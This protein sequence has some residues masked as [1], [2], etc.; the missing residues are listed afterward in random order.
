MAA[1][2][3]IHLLP[4]PLTID[5]VI[6][7]CP[8]QRHVEPKGFGISIK[9]LSIEMRTLLQQAIMHWPELPLGG[10]RFGRL[11]GQ[12]CV[13]MGTLNRKVTVHEP[14]FG[15]RPLQYHANPRLHGPTYGALEI[16][17]FNDGDAAV[18]GTARVVDISDG[19]QKI[20]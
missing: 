15:R 1:Q 12:Q 6:K 3:T 18:S 5:L 10:R 14:Y 8:E 9:R 13:R 2:G 20:H 19:Y 16:T 17:I 4:Y 11:C 7:R